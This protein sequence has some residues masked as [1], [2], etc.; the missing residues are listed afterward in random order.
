MRAFD[1]DGWRLASAA[2][3]AAGAIVLASAAPVLASAVSILAPVE[4]VSASASPALA[5]A[6]PALPVAAAAATQQVDER[7]R[8]SFARAEI[9][10]R[11]A[12][13]DQA[14]ETLTGVIEAL[15]PPATSGE[16]D[17]EAQALLIRSLA[18]RAD[19]LI[20]AGERDAA[21]ADLEQL[22]T[23][24]PRVSIDGFRLSDV[25][26][27][28]FERAEARLV[29][30]LTFLAA[31]LNARIRVDGAPLPEG[32]TT[33]DLLAG[34]H[35]IE[36][37]IPGFTRQAQ[38]V[39]VR[40]DRA[41][42]VEILLE[43]ISAVVRL[44]TRPAG[45]TVM[46][47]GEV[48][49][50][51]S[52]TPPRDWV[53]TG[54]AA[55]Y[56]R[57]EFS[58]VMEV[59]GLMTGRHDVEV[60]LDGYRTF[61]APIAFSDLADYDVGS[62]I[63]TANLGL[64]LLRDLA[65]EAEVWVDGRRTQPEP[66][67]R[68]RGEGAPASNA[69]R[70]S[71]E[72]GEYRITVSQADAGVFE[73]TVT[74]ADRRNIMLTVRLRPGLTFLG[75]IGSDRMGAETLEDSLRAA[76]DD[77]GFWAFLDRTDAA[78]RILQRTG[79]T[80]QRL[81]AAAV[82]GVDS[83]RALDWQ[84]LQTTVSREL[85]GSIFVLGVLDDDELAASADLWVWPS[86]PGPAVAERVRVSLADSDA[87]ESVA[88]GL[89]E[90]MTFQRSWTG[91]DLIASGIATT[92]VVAVLAPNGP[93]A[94]A[95]VRVGDRLVTVAGNNVATVAGSADWFATFPPGSIVA[96]GMRG[97]DGERTVELRMGST[98][99]VV[100]TAEADRFYSV[101]WG[102]TAAAVGRLDAGVPSWVAELN[103]A[104]V[105]LHAREWAAAARL[106]AGIQAPGGTGV[107][108]GLVQYWLG[109]ALSETGDVDGARAAFER[110]LDQ[111]EA[112]YLT[113]DGLFLAPMAR[114]RL[115]ALDGG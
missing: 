28:R 22:L 23:L 98:P 51:T 56:P 1:V 92:P 44:M 17:G 79:V 96:L 103:Q 38:E 94:A 80:E 104:A 54:D 47:D 111:P 60:V 18:Y 33:Y 112:R 15:L 14:I 20:F 13:P 39:E 48:V 24:Y 86:A 57:R 19:A 50:Q 62:I 64:V 31:P 8:L 113:N 53:P 52:G 108:E 115:V 97:P 75:V 70:L 25:G 41:V 85:P 76:F 82:E 2:G 49:G 9:L 68:S 101:V 71:L 109:V 84:R 37:S 45:A 34:T 90:A 27:G 12:E 99:T 6:G 43:R 69:Y 46:I 106:L 4:P 61:S 63:L 65:P 11:T 40:A 87:L 107:G 114:A 59:E 7:M 102:M 110:S 26:V 81:R 16:I 73:E 36:A 100:G 95:G 21:D 89:S 72:P 32:T 83:S 66:P 30:T 58:A 67:S 42:E 5:S 105:L 78:A 77:F 3:R 29:G 10:Y 74:V 55:R 91:M 88:A 35:F 93:A